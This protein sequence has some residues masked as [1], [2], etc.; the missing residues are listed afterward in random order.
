MRDLRLLFD[1]IAR[2]PGGTTKTLTGLPCTVQRSHA[3][4]YRAYVA[5]HRSS[6]WPTMTQAVEHAASA[7]RGCQVDVITLRNRL[8]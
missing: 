8:A 2:Y 7:A 3:E 5:G 6:Y 4:S 1:A